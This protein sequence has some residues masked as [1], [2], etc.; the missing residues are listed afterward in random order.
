MSRI[1]IAILACLVLASS[2][3][4]RP[5]EDYDYTT[6]I[7]IEVDIKALSNVTCDVYNEKIPVPEVQRDVMRV[8]FYHPTQDRLITEAFVS[9]KGVNPDGSEYIGGKVS[10]VPGQYRIIIY[11]F[12]TESTLI[13]N[14][15]SFVGSRA[16]T[17][18]LSEK[19]MKS[20]AIKSDGE[21][22][23]RILWQPD[24]LLVARSF[25]EDIPYHAG[26]YTIHANASSIIESYYLQ[27]KVDG[28]Q[29]VSTAYA[30]LGG[31]VPSTQLANVDRDYQNESQIY[32]PLLHS[33]DKGEAVICNVFNTFGRIP[34]IESDLKVTFDL[35]TIDG[36]S[37]NRTF[38]L[39]DLF[40]SE[41]C[42]KHHW[43]LIDETIKVDPP[44]HPSTGGG[45][46][47]A[48]EDW[49]EERRD[50]TI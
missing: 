36:R 15:D 38:D 2:C 42:I 44:P 30:I 29:Y 9:N 34:N 27:I 17:D 19:K 47:P 20:L 37:V 4:R 11:S 12:G 41:D 25:E 3:H 1:K 23:R 39:T 8:M 45:F 16:Y 33:D 43:L 48:V 6:E 49:E 26:I 24:H 22:S 31:M 35:K 21:D 13:A 28:L 5:L 7:N 32:I 46:D 18:P 10:I 14:Y 40:E 50:I